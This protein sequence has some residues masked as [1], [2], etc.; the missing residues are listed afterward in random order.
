MLLTSEDMQGLSQS[1][2]S[3]RECIELLEELNAPVEHIVLTTHAYEHKIFV[4]AFQR[5]YGGA[6]VWVVPRCAS[7][8]I[9]VVD[10]N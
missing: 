5:R 6:K 9:P 4:P 1:Q 8:S 7:R 3:G 2:Q 10:R